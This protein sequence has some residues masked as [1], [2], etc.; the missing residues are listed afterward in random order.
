MD[1]FTANCER[2]RAPSILAFANDRLLVEE[3]GIK[4]AALPNFYGLLAV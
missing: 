1:C 4:A 3:V 2:S